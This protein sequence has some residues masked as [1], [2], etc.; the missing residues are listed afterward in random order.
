MSF[1]LVTS[2]T[3]VLALRGFAATVTKTLPIIN[4]AISPDGFS[5]SFVAFQSLT[6]WPSLY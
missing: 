1:F 2:V 4:K 3:L 5:R 6:M